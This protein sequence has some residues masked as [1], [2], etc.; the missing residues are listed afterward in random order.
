MV[1]FQRPHFFLMLLGSIYGKIILQIFNLSMQFSVLQFSIVLGWLLDSS[2]HLSSFLSLLN[3]FSVVFVLSNCWT[4]FACSSQGIM[5]LP[6]CK[7]KRGLRYLKLLT[8]NMFWST[9]Q[10]S[11]H[12]LSLHKHPKSYGR[13]LRKKYFEGPHTSSKVKTI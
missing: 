1:T 13:L 2:A 5:P 11:K 9:F 3:C 12:I 10:C 7:R 8:F 4:F 6:L